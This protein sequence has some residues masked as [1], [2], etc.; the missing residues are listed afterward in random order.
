MTQ[1]IIDKLHA[2]LYAVSPLAG[3][4][5][6]IIE[7]MGETIWVEALEKMLLALD[8]AKRKEVIEF[9][10]A[11]NL[12]KAVEILEANNVDVDAIIT[13]VSTSVMNEVLATKE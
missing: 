8:D 3:D 10:N 1:E 9:L 7:E 6:R 11:D 2:T 12:D 4:R 13:E 5:E